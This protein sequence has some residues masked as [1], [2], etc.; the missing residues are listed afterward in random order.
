MA[1]PVV[2]RQGE[3]FPGFLLRDQQARRGVESAREK[4]D[5]A[6]H[7]YLPGTSPQS[8]LWSWSP[9]RIGRPESRIQLPK[10]AAE[11]FSH[12]GENVTTCFWSRSLTATKSRAQSKSRRSARTNLISSRDPRFSGRFAAII[13]LPGALTSTILT[14]RGSTRSRATCPP[15]SRRTVLP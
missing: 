14:T 10:S 5:R 9:S 7:L 12:T 11:S 1:L 8:N 3:D 13:P 4:D 6:I 15:V 2:E